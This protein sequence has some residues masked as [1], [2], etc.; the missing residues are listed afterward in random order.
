M[1]GVIDDPS[2]A[3][4]GVGVSI[5][6]PILIKTIIA[7]LLERLVH[8]QLWS[9]YHFLM[10]TQGI[11]CWLRNVPV[12]E[13]A[14]CRCKTFRPSSPTGKYRNTS[15]ILLKPLPP[16]RIQALIPSLLVEQLG[17]RGTLAILPYT[18]RNRLVS[19]FVWTASLPE[20]DWLLVGS[21][22]GFFN[23]HRR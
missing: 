2:A 9:L 8:P 18:S 13:P 17:V 5:Y 19:A 21:L 16:R 11:L 1:C 4:C 23:N 6:V 7:Y 20:T 3:I 22:K 15:S 12:H 10:D 14:Y